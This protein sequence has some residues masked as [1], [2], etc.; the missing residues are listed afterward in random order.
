MEKIGIII[1]GICGR[2][3]SLIL[4]LASEREE[5]IIKGGVERKDHRDIGKEILPGVTISNNLESISTG[6]EVVIDFTNPQATVEFV[7]IAVEKNNKMVIGTTGFSQQQMDFIKKS[8]EKI[9]ILI[10]PNM[11]YGVNCLFEIIQFAADILK[12]YETE[13]IEIHH[14]FKKDSP[15]GTAKKIAEIICKSK[16][17]SPEKVLKYGRV[18]KTGERTKE[19]IGMHSVRIGDIVGEHTVLF[20]GKG[21]IIEITHRCYNREAFAI[22][23]LEAAKFIYKKEKGIYEMKEVISGSK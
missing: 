16:N 4:K 20:G 17:Y 15:S 14:H 8:S 11:S 3:G 13:I 12:G 7:K 21:E 5:F 1:C 6:K 22:G 19:E 23:A 2:M 9:P 18:G 10:S